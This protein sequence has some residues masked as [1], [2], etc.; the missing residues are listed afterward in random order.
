[1][2][3]RF[4]RR[5]RDNTTML[6]QSRKSKVGYYVDKND[7][8]QISVELM[9]M[10]YSSQ[11]V[12]LTATW[13]YIEAPYSDYEFGTLYWLDIASCDHSDR[14]AANNSLFTYS[15]PSVQSDFHGR[16]VYVGNHLHDGAVRQEVMKNGEI[17][18]SANPR[19]SADEGANGNAHISHIPSCFDV[20]HVAPGDEFALTASYDT[21]KYAPMVNEDG[22]LEPIMGISLAYIVKGAAP[23]GRSGNGGYGPA[24]AVAILA[25]LVLVAGAGYV[26][27]VRKQHKEWPKWFLRRQKYRSLGREEGEFADP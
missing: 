1:M 26:L 16:I 9:N 23:T 15:S 12:V 3:G 18:C 5:Q 7:K 20:G 11:D 27:Y 14:P 19:Y 4:Q 25:T 6:S 8:F 2:E 21:V 10:H 24:I 13:K 22:S 17:I